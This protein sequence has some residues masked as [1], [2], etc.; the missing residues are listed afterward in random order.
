MLRRSL[1][2]LSGALLMTLSVVTTTAE[3]APHSTRLYPTR[4]SYTDS[5]QPHTAFPWQQQDAPLGASKRDGRLHVSRV[6][7]TLDVAQFA[8]ARILGATLYLRE[9]STADCTKRAIGVWQTAPVAKD[10]TWAGAPRR[11]R[12]LDDFTATGVCPASPSFDVATAVREAVERNEPRIT[13]E[14]AV[15]APFERDTAYGRTLS[16]YYKATVSVQHNH[17]PS[18]VDRHRYNSGKQCAT[19]APYPKLSTW[20]VALEALPADA[21]PGDQSPASL[22]V[23]FALWPQDDPTART[24]KT[25]RHASTTWVGRA[26]FPGLTDGKVY[27]W[28]A[29]AADGADNG[30]WSTPCHFVADA[31]NPATPAITSPNYPPHDGSAPVPVGEDGVFVFD[32]R[33]DTDT[34]GFGYTWGS[35]IPVG[36][37]SIGELGRLICADPLD[38]D[39]AVR[40]DH[41]GG[42]ATT[43]LAPPDTGPQTLTAWSVDAAGNRS[44]P[45]E[46]TMLI[47]ATNPSVTVVGDRPRWNQDVT[48]RFAPVPALADRTVEF[49]YR[50]DSREQQVVSAGADGTAAITFRADN[51][52]GHTV[53]VS[54]RSANGWTS[55]ATTWSHRFYPWPDVRSDVY[56]DSGEPTGGVGVPGTFTFSP[57]AGW[58]RVSAYRY[59]VDGGEYV[60]VPA[61]ADGTATITLTPTTSGYHDLDVYA[62]NADG[63]PGTYSKLFSF[64]VA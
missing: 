22:A 8:G 14:V 50:V 32:A 48:L 35:T 43:T 59:S 40:A 26:D 21:D 47:P 20:F 56:T 55:G 30:A 53:T 12:W 61:D 39:H 19:T 64:N 37:C 49:V 7:L 45:T 60:D 38:G 41:P 36:G 42:T 58:T 23:D 51:P 15:P 46:Y 5:A 10:P 29:R 27:S 3:A 11:K 31:V 33:G 54:S 13:L 1:T 9:S 18:I 28:Q 6:Y 52:S 57:P 25:A 17:I 4:A 63:Q 62:I 2:A 16:G 44:A 34:V 24:E